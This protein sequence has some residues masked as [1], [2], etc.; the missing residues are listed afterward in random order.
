[1]ASTIIYPTTIFPT[2]GRRHAVLI[3]L[4][5]LG[6][7]LALGWFL[8]GVSIESTSAIQQQVRYL[9]YVISAL[10]LVIFTLSLFLGIM[11]S[12]LEV[13]TQELRQLTSLSTTLAPSPPMQSP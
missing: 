6:L 3:F 9:S 7:L 2:T 11:I 12:Q 13:I 5:V 4:M 1:M 8:N 10:G